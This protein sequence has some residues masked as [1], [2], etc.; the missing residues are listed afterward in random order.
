MLSNLHT[1]AH[2]HTQ[3][4]TI[5]NLYMYMAIRRE[6]LYTSPIARKTKKFIITRDVIP[7]CSGGHV[8]CIAVNREIATASF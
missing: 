4:R 2:T 7:G 1:Y 6:S 8:K 5:S 3:T